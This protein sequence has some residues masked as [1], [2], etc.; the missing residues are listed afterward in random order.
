[1]DNDASSR[2]V[3][4]AA[5]EFV[6]THLHKHALSCYWFTLLSRLGLL[7]RYA[8]SA[9]SHHFKVSVTEFLAEEGT[10]ARASKLLK[11]IE[12]YTP[13]GGVTQGAWIQ[14]ET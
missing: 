7:M 5:Q 11:G 4:E 10:R 8:P 13:L 3:A 14:T 2:K 1:M 9:R 12:L 6:A